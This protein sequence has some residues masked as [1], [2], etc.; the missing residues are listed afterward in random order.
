MQAMI[1]DVACVGC[2]S[3]EGICPDVFEVEDGVSHVKTVPVPDD[4]EDECREAAENCPVQAI[5][6][7]D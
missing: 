4:C 2:G 5:S 6:L 3:C 1:N 7:N